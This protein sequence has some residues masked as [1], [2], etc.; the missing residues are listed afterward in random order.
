MRDLCLTVGSLGFKY[1]FQ[2]DEK[3]KN[4]DD[5]IL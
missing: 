3:K 1:H 5:E 4:W 2:I